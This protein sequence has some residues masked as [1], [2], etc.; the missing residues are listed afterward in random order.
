M[1]LPAGEIDAFRETFN[2]EARARL[3]PDLLRPALRPDIDVSVA[4]SSLQLAHWLEYLGP[5][6]IG[7]PGPLLR[8]SSVEIEKPRIVGSGHL[9]AVLRQDDAT[10]DAIGFGLAERFPPDAVRS[11]RWDVLF[12]LEKN[13]W[14][15]SERAQARLIDLRPDDSSEEPAA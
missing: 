13:T 11:R 4:E 6:G 5:H 1:D 14:N 7:N 15:G 10:L 9:K 3:T 2:R 8:T 12:R